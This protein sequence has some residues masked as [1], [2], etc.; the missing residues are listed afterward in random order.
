MTDNDTEITFPEKLHILFEPARYKILYGGR[1][2]AKSWG[3][4][5]ALIALGATK[6]LRILCAREIQKSIVDSVHKLLADQ[7]AELGLDH[8]YIVQGTTIV[9]QNGTAFYFSG[10]RN[11]TVAQLKSHEGI[12]IC[13]VEEAQTVSKMS[14]MVLTPTIRKANSEIWLTFNPMFEQDETYKRFVEHPPANSLSVKINWRDNPWFPEV[15]DEERRMLL[16]RDPDLYQHVWEGECLKWLDGAIYAAQIKSAHKDGRIGTVPYDPNF[17]VYTA[18]DFGLGD[19]TSIWWFQCIDQEVYFID[20]Y[21][22]CGEGVSHYASQLLGRD[23]V[24]DLVQEKNPYR[25]V[26]QPTHITTIKAKKGDPI[27]SLAH[28]AAY[29]Y[30]Y[31]FFPHDAYNKTQPASGKSMFEQLASALGVASIRPVPTHMVQERIQAA[32]LLFHRCHFDEVA[33]KEG[34]N[35]LRQY[36]RELQTD[37]V[38]FKAKAKHDWASHA[39]DAFGYGLFMVKWHA[40]KGRAEA[41]HHLA[42]GSSSTYTM[43]DALR[44]HD[45]AVEK[46][47]GQR[48]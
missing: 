8:F 36:Q 21:S 39:A 31:H 18:W 22:H 27:P 41:G 4:A 29:D 30:A 37:D 35:A 5:R 47:K 3:V 10:L 34:L 2:G 38:S 7:I 45:R 15:L 12:D 20:Y 6:K 16:K 13:W 17:P 33:T 44:D 25:G 28:R 40:E 46:R 42:I 23:V 1:G 24:I 32:R 11:H 19:D 43:D 48:R 26:D 9:G 14:W